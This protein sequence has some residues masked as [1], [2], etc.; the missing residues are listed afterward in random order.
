[1][2]KVLIFL[3]A[4]RDVAFATVEGDKPKI[5]VFQIMKR[6][7]DTLYFA[8]DTHK[9]VYQQLQKNPFVELLAMDGNISVRVKGKAIFDVSDSIGKEIYETNPVLIRLYHSYSD[10]V[11]FRL[12]ISELDYYDLTPTPPIL[13]H[14]NL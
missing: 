4:H 2:E 12:A 1:M 14:Y 3:S 13:K 9:E 6:E 7:K 11:Y 10:L 8:T 5:R